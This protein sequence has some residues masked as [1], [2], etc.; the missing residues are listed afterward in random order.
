MPVIHCNFSLWH[1]NYCTPV[2]V[3]T[4]LLHV[5]CYACHHI[6]FAKKITEHSRNE[7]LSREVTHR[8]PVMHF[9]PFSRNKRNILVIRIYCRGM[10]V[11]EKN[12]FFMYFMRDISELSSFSFLSLEMGFRWGC[13]EELLNWITFFYVH[14][15][16][17]VFCLSI[18]MGVISCA[19]QT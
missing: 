17:F 2:H 1:L 15:W 7:V 5:V 13:V 10:K 19:L 18:K 8:T 12:V 16:D 6:F 14:F 11:V 3:A 4:Y 9:H